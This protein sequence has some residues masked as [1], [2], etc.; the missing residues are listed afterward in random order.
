METDH[1]GEFLI[2][3]EKGFLQ[4]T[5]I[6]AFDSNTLSSLGGYD[7]KSQ[8]EVKSYNFSAKGESYVNTS[9]FV[10]FY[11]ELKTCFDSLKGKACL[12][13]FVHNFSIEIIFDDWGRITIKGSLK[14]YDH[15]ENE[16]IFNLVTDQTFVP[17]LLSGLE[18][19]V[20]RYN[21]KLQN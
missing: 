12:S 7:T 3:A 13:S 1:K 8:I 11:N 21:N 6:E 9:Q 19:I 15:I 4:L 14:E 16:L 5:I 17:Q 2:R 18:D 10:T 20:S